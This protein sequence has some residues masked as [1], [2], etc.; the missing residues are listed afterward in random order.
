MIVA[1]ALGYGTGFYTTFF[2]DE[3]MKEFF[4]I[5]EKYRLICF[6][7]VGIPFEWPEASP[8]KKLEDFVIFESF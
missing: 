8:K 1:R 5:P 3:K 4:N 7:P 2:P 6:T